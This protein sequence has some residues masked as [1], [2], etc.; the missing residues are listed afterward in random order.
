MSPHACA[1][2][3]LELLP[4]AFLDPLDESTQRT[5]VVIEASPHLSSAG[6]ELVPA[7]ATED[8]AP[9]IVEVG[10]FGRTPAGRSEIDQQLV[11]PV[12]TYRRPVD[13]FDGLGVP[14]S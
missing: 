14:G 9:A 5:P 2:G 4:A 6:E 12:R 3:R 10:I 8:L 11:Y 1:W 13:C 7:Q